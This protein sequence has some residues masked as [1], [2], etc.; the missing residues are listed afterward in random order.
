MAAKSN[1]QL[2][3]DSREDDNRKPFRGCFEMK[4][5][6]PSTQRDVAYRIV[7]SST[8]LLSPKGHIA[9]CNA[10]I[11]CTPTFHHRPKVENQFM[12]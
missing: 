10:A 4:S 11:Q 6:N 5:S 3:L 2:L 7:Q 12:A 9:A 1:I 8:R